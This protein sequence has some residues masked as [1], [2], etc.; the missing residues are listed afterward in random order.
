[1]MDGPHPKGYEEGMGTQGGLTEGFRM[2][3]IKIA[4]S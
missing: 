2:L 3:A 1:M 4:F